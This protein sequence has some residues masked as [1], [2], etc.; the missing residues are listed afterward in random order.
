MNIIIS[1]VTNQ[2]A[3]VHIKLKSFLTIR[4]FFFDNCHK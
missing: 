1:H 2:L 4:L 3:R